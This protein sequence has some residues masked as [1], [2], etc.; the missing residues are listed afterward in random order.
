MVAKRNGIRNM[1]RP[2]T[3]LIDMDVRRDRP[4]VI[5]RCV[6][7]ARRDGPAVMFLSFEVWL[8][9]NIANSVSISISSIERRSWNCRRR[10]AEDR[11]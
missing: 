9:W 6:A 1:T 3:R 8:V 10:R 11:E 5:R 7:E 2:F 4:A